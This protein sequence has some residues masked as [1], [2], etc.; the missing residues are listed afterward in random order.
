MHFPMPHCGAVIKANIQA[1][2]HPGVKC[3]RK[4]LLLVAEV[5]NNYICVYFKFVKVFHFLPILHK[6]QVP[7]SCP[8]SPQQLP[9]SHSFINLLLI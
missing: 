9:L 7:L 8:L 3:T 6:L 4:L 5:H 1:G 2:K